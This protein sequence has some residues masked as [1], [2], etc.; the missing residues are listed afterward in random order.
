MERQL[1]ISSHLAIH[2][3]EKGRNCA[4]T[5]S[6]KQVAAIE[7]AKTHFAGRLVGRKDDGYDDMRRVHNGLIDKRPLV[8]AHCAGAADVADA[9]KL[10]RALGLDISVRGG[11]HNVAGRAVADGG[12]MIDLAGMR[13]VQVDPK[14]KTARVQG[15]T[16]WGG[17]NREAQLYGLATTGGVISTTGV[18][19]LTLGGGLGWLMPKYGMALDNLRSVEV[20]SAEGKMLRASADENPDLFWA[21]RGGGGNFGVATSF[22]FKLHA[23]GPMVTGGLVAHPLERAKD[24]LKFFRDQTA[25]LPDEVMAFAGLVH[26]PDGSGAKLSA[27]LVCHCGDARKAERVLAPFKS[28]GPPVLDAIGPI[29][30]EAVNGMLDAKFPKGA[31]N[32]W[33]SGFIDKLSDG[34]ID[35]MVDS[36]KRCPTEMGSMLIEHFHGAACRI[37]PDATAFQHRTESFNFAILGQWAKKAGTKSCI[38]WVRKTHGAMAPFIAKRQYVNYMGDDAGEAGVAEAYG[39]NLKRLQQVKATYDPDNVFHLNH[40]IR[41]A[42]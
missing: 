9:V 8:I 37:A 38:D 12:L 33:K 2:C 14:A 10:G 41:P 17:F 24:M 35:V 13:A 25:R 23:V 21:L 3:N 27:M 36:F 20:V 19:G 16:T 39:K 4:V 42:R 26:A 32:Y 28:F 34:A 7:E 22:E 15:G 6:K 31:L 30:Y 29:S 11:G 18:G 5:L 40:N 1:A